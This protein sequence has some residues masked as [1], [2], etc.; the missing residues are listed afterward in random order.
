MYDDVIKLGGK[1]K[2]IKNSKKVSPPGDLPIVE[3]I[4]RSIEGADLEAQNRLAEKKRS[5]ERKRRES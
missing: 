2:A 4:R 3:S 1:S 5:E